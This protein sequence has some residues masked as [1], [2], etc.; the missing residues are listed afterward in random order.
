MYLNMKCIIKLEDLLPNI[1][2]MLRNIW[3][4]KTKCSLQLKMTMDWDEINDQWNKI[5][6]IYVKLFC[7]LLCGS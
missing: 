4:L 2:F 7:F 3:I 1:V 6:Y 5:S